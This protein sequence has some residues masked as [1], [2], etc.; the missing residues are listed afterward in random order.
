MLVNVR[1]TLQINPILCAATEEN[2]NGPPLLMDFSR[3]I[4]DITTFD[5]PGT[6]WNDESVKS[7]PATLPRVTQLTIMSRKM[8]SPVAVTNRQGVT[9]SVFYI[10]NFTLEN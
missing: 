5:E 7:Q 3:R 4:D 9:V 1:L 10:V 6:T 8:K 2:T